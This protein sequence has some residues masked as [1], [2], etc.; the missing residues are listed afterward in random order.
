MTPKCFWIPPGAP[1]LPP[2]P[3]PRPKEQKFWMKEMSSV[4]AKNRWLT[5]SR[6]SP[7]WSS[8]L[9]FKVGQLLHLVLRPPPEAMRA[10]TTAKASSHLSQKFK[11]SFLPASQQQ[12]VVGGLEEVVGG[13]GEPAGPGR[14]R[15]PPP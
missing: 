4:L 14:R 7:S 12:V 3:D 5:K 11:F 15:Q 10:L 2:G 6:R 9:I 13:R 8:N 1:Y